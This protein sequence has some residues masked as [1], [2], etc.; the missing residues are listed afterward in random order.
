MWT[1]PEFVELRVG[2]KSPCTSA[3]A[4]FSGLPGPR[5]T[6]MSPPRGPRVQWYENT[7]TR[8]GCRRRLSPVE[9]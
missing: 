2:S 1:K 3:Y 6:P 8:I 7:D 5:A 4:E 9:L